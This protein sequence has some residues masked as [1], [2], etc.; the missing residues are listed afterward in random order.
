[1]KPYWAY[2]KYNI[3]K[4]EY[5]DINNILYSIFRITI[6]I[7]DNFSLFFLF[8]LSK[9]MI[10]L[11][12]TYHKQLDQFR[13]YGTKNKNIKFKYIKINFN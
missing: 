10:I 12:P 2:Y 1:M 5:N 7:C 13:Q 4:Y 9:L 3:W 6:L 8:F 11:R